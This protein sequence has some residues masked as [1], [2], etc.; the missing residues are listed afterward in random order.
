[1][2]ARML[3]KAAIFKCMLIRRRSQSAESVQKQRFFNVLMLVLL[4][5]T[6]LRD[7]GDWTSSRQNESFRGDYPAYN[8]HRRT[9]VSA[10]QPSKRCTVVPLAASPNE[11]ASFTV[12]TGLDFADWSSQFTMST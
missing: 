10:L 6:R 9:R 11:H 1:M 7:S 4:S 2:V 8:L 12:T 3:K 5:K